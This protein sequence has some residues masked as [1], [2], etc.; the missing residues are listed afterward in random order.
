MGKQRKLTPEAPVN[1]VKE[2]VT[3]GSDPSQSVGEQAPVGNPAKSRQVQGKF[4]ENTIAQAFLAYFQSKPY[5][6]VVNLI[7]VLQQAPTIPVTFIDEPQANK[8]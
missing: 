2:E 4:L 7:N 3:K 1:E 6:E 8:G 5:N